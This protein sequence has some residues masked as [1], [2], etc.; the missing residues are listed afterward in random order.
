MDKK[1]N[2]VG[3]TSVS[4]SNNM[5]MEIIAYRNAHDIDIKFEDG[6]EVYHKSYDPFVKGK[7][8]YPSVALIGKTKRMRNGY[9]CTITAARGYNDIDVVFSNGV[10]NKHQTMSNWRAGI[11]GFPLDYLKIRSKELAL[12]RVGLTRKMNNGIDATIIAYK[13][14]NDID[15][16]FDTGEIKRGVRY[17]NFLRGSIATNER[18]CKV[19]QI[20]TMSNGMKATITQYRNYQDIDIEFEDGKKRE[21]V[22]YKEFLYG[23][24]AYNA[25]DE[26]SITKIGETVFHKKTGMLLTLVC[27][28]N[29]TDIDLEFEDGALV[30]HKTYYCFK[31]GIVQYPIANYVSTENRIGIQYT[32]NNGLKAECIAYSSTHDISVKFLFDGTVV[33]HKSWHDFVTG[34]IAHPMIKPFSSMLEKNVEKYL[35]EHGID[36]SAQ[37]IFKR[38]KLV[39]KGGG[40][41]SY[42]FAVNDNDQQ[43]IALIECQGQQHFFPIDLFGGE[44]QF[45]I[46]QMHDELKR[47]FA[48][49]HNIKLIEVPYTEDTYER[50]S[51][52]LDKFTAIF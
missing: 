42:D 12:L 34:Y 30:N 23:R 32:M 52:F 3:E 50:V 5:K 1:R 39:G 43:I 20:N 22:R 49:E 8:K 28:R 16:Q 45:E 26:L 4:L 33:Q 2:R 24:I 10:E 35:L 27:Y 41:L 48:K 19:G 38:E 18:F 37:V 40:Y 46:Q 29:A 36:Y 7:I 6:A 17:G 9:D 11:I 44:L 25:R 31:K 14:E 47:D 51:V 13:N 21:H 15:I